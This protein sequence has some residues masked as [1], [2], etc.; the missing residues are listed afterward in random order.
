M[1]ANPQSDLQQVKSQFENFRARRTGKERLPENLWAAAVALLDHYP[2]KVVWRE[3]RLK[4]EYLKRHAGLAKDRA[5]PTREKSPTFLALTTGELRAI[6]NGT[7]K[8]IAALSVNHGV[9]C[10][11]VIERVDG[12]RLLLNLPVEWSCIEALCASF[13]RG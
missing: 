1:S 4:P 5:A 2:F 9:E 12:S 3:L 13:L 10:R 11:L 7:N 6:K 8:K